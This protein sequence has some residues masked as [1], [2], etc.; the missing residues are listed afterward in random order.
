MPIR[1][2]PLNPWSRPV[3]LGLMLLMSATAS[4]LHAGCLVEER[5][6]SNFD[7]PANQVCLA[8]GECGVEC[9]S[10]ADCGLGLRCSLNRCVGASAGPLACPD[11]MV[12][13]A[14]AFCV[15]RYEASRRD[16]TEAGVGL[17]ES[18][19][20]SKQGVLPWQVRDNATAQ[21]ACEAAGKALCTPQQWRLSC[22]GQAGTAY[23]YGDS[24]DPSVCNGIDLFGIEHLHLLPTG[25]LL[26]CKSDWGVYDING[27]LWEHVAA[28]SDRTVR[29]GAFNCLDSRS[30]HRC[31]YVPGDWA[32]SARGFRCCLLPGGIDAGLDV[33]DPEDVAP[34]DVTGEF[35]SGCIEDDAGGTVPDVLTDTLSDTTDSSQDA[36]VDT[37]PDTGNDLSV[38]SAQETGFDGADDQSGSEAGNQDAADGSSPEA[39]AC[40]PDMVRGTSFCMDRYEASHVDAT[41]TSVG[42]SPVA[43]SMAGVLP[44]FPV[45]LVM[46]RSACQAAGKR[47]CRLDEWIQGCRGSANT[48]YSYGNSYSA[49]VC[50]G[51]DAF[52]SCGS[53]SCSG[54]SQCPYPHCFSSP[55][56]EGPGPCGASFQVVPTGSFASC[57]SEY[58]AYDINGNVWEL[59][60]TTDGLEHFRGGAF[61]CGDSEALHRCDHDGTWGP[62]ARGFRCCAD[63]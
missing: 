42:T 3:A 5:C 30:L 7:C 55:S 45:N 18:I 29:G 43:S 46:A 62:S 28:G 53:P 34:K 63:L 35:E 39:G 2:F 24:Y 20:V 11:G 47:L 61:N 48:V 50:N 60:D 10:D 13:V 6:F 44:W 12:S 23:G 31:D 49:T 58:G 14:D 54:L 4:A 33:F 27:N 36:V 1:S 56:Q 22:Q 25:S 37:T 51:I 52:C 21:A 17:D 32:P 57:E 8:G 38:D 41:A 40:P 15:D 16:A 26:G 59:A 19:A 9:S